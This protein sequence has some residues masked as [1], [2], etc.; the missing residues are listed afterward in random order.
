MSGRARGRAGRGGRGAPADLGPARKPGAEETKPEQSSGRSRGRAPGPKAVAPQAATAVP[1]VRPQATATAAAAAA[2][3]KPKAAMP[4]EEGMSRMS[5]RDRPTSREKSGPRGAEGGP[6]GPREGKSGRSMRDL[7]I[8]QPHTKPAHVASKKGTSGAP[9]KI[10]SNFFRLLTR[11]DWAIYQYNVQFEP[12]VPFIRKRRELL[13]N[14]ADRLGPTR[15]FDGM[16]LFMPLRLEERVSDFQSQSRFDETPHTVKITLTNELPPSSP[17]CIQMFNIIFRKVM[18]QLGMKQVGRHYFSVNEDDR[19]QVPA[20]KLEVWPGYSTSILQYE[21]NVLLC[22]DVQHKVVRCDTVLDVL[23]DLGTKAKERRLDFH[24][25]AM[26]ELIGTSVLTRYN[27]KTYRIDD[28]NWDMTPK[29]KFK[30]SQDEEV[31]FLEYY[32]KQYNLKIEDVNQPMLISRMKRAPKRGQFGIEYAALVPQLC[33]MTGLTTNMREDFRVMKDLA[34]HT[35]IEPKQRSHTL[36]SFMQLMKKNPEALKNLEQ[37]GLSFASDL[38]EFG[39]RQLPTEKIN[40]RS[41]SSTYRPDNPDW[42]ND[43]R[44]NHL[45]STKDLSSWLLLFTRRD[46][47]KGQGFLQTLR[48]VGP[49]MGVRIMEPKVIELQDNKT[50]TY[51]RA[52]KDNLDKSIVMVACILTSNTKQTYDAIKRFCCVDAPVPSQVVVARTLSKPKMIM[53]VC[54]KICI[55]LNCKM[56]GEV[57]ALDIPL[58]NMMVVGIDTYHDSVNKGQSVGGFVA[59]MNR[60]CTKYHSRTTFQHSGQELMDQLGTCMTASLR[61]YAEVNGKLPARIFVYRDGVG[62]GQLESI[63]N[64]ELQQFLAAFKQ[65]EDGYKYPKATIF[66]YS[67]ICLFSPK[68]SFIVV[69]KGINTRLFLRSGPGMMNPLPGTVVDDHVTRSEWYDFFLVSQSVRQ[70]TVSPT[71]YNV[72]HDSSDL[73]PDHIQRLTYKLTHLYYN[74]PG[75]IRVP[76]PCQ[77]AHKLAFLVG[78]SVHKAP[79]LSLADR[80]YFL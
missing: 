77:Y 26:K 42:T 36:H 34:T 25:L 15:V 7:Q 32:S 53:S 66:S 71:H 14:L 2:P 61:K 56:G 28:I 6:R 50:E 58:D 40:V 1:A 9:V 4:L 35:R 80:L 31:T 51:L 72:V 30:R 70:G 67:S 24:E 47:D 20:H 8:V 11:P 39:G 21:E 22:A 59:S 76:A 44:S 62:D 57:W 68:F 23:Y 46:Q 49:S 52:I 65:I 33:F 54:T 5:V 45:I 78:Q 37:W 19:A 27:N 17:T 73:K 64:Y 48:R 79:D 41:R 63:V 10:M 55:Q 16:Q 38:L 69:K 18:R 75:T 3:T 29:S 74:W 43:I 12:E 13:H 60:T